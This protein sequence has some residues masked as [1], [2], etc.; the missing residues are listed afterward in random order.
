MRVCAEICVIITVADNASI[1]LISVVGL[2]R[3]GDLDSGIEVKLI[4]VMLIPNK[5]SK[6]EPVNL[7]F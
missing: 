1:I 3:S 5:L 6:Q 4:T 7:Q 2:S